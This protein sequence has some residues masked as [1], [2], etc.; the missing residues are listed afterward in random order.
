MT[1][2]DSGDLKLCGHVERERMCV[3]PAGHNGPHGQDLDAAEAL[4]VIPMP[5][6]QRIL[7]AL[8]SVAHAGSGYAALA[9]EL[10]AAVERKP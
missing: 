8:D 7:A 5:L 6:A 10:R 9:S 3:L 2:P 4:V 1:P